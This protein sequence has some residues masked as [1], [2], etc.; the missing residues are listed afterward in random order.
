MG[1]I[2]QPAATTIGTLAKALTE[3]AAAFDVA[4]A[5]A[6]FSGVR[7]LINS[8][9]L[10]GLLGT[11]KR[12]LVGIDWFRSEPGALDTLA[13][14]RESQVRVV[15]GKYLIATPNC[16]PR[17]TFHPKA[18]MITDKKCTLVVGS[19][20]LSANGLRKSA[21][22]SLVTHDPG[23]TSAFANWFDAEWANASLWQRIRTT[24]IDQYPTAKCRE[25]VTTEDDDIPDD[26]SIRVRWVTPERLRLMRA[27]QNLWA[28]VGHLHN[29]DP[30]G[31]PG[32]DIQFS[33]MTRVFFGYPARIVPGNTH[34][35]DIPLSMKGAQTEI[36]PMVFNDAS[37]MDRLSLPVPGQSGWPE[38]YD[39]E[40][41]LFTKAADASFQVRMASRA[42]R[43]AWRRQSQTNGFTVPM[44]R[45]RREWGVF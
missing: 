45:N 36:R 30:Q 38:K 21:E 7:E 39:D 12:F 16:Q 24:Y 20:N 32:T 8:T 31:L 6:T 35:L 29:R 37:S 23:D 9:R 1:L 34:L 4:V 41:L 15:D 42:D 17:R 27:A 3:S 19:A 33:Q 44:S 26:N 25:Y 43:P 28:D 18:Y 22:L 14:L 11:K 13:A 5:Y 2:T 40:T 10:A